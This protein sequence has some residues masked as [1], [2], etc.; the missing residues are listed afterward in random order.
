MTVK[1]K[2]YKCSECGSR[3]VQ[4]QATEVY[5]FGGYSNRLCWCYDCGY[6]GTTAKF[7]DA[8][9]KEYLEEEKLKELQ[10]T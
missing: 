7:N 8:S 5:P 9:A 2:W 1:N 10:P 3:N 6:Q 4:E